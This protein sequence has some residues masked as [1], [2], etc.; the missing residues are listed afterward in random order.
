MSLASFEVYLTAK[1]QTVQYKSPVFMEDE[2]LSFH[3]SRYKR[4]LMPFR[5]GLIY[6]NGKPE[7]PMNHPLLRQ[8]EAADV[9]VITE[10]RKRKGWDN[11]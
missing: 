5:Y 10:I 11:L 4:F 7:D 8:V 1:A 9:A 2:E 3:H 6:Q